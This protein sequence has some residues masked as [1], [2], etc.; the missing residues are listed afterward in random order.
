MS[1]STNCLLALAVAGLTA[2]ACS[3]VTNDSANSV[4]LSAAFQT[5]PAGFS[6]NSNSFDESGDDG[7]PFSPGT[8]D[9]ASGFHGQQGQNGERNDKDDHHDGFGKG[10]IRGLLM[11]G[12]LGS[13]FLGGVPFS[14]G[15]GF[16]PFGFFSLEDDCTFDATTGRV[17]CP[18]RIKRGLTISSSF[19]FKDAAGNAQPKFDRGVTNS[20]NAKIAVIGT[21]TRHGDDDGDDDND[22][23]TS[24]LDHR[25]DRTV[26]GLATGSTER[27]VNGTASAHEEITGERHDVKFTAVRDVSDVTTNVVIP[28]GE[29]RPTIPKSG[30]IVRE[31]K[32][33]ITPE[34]GETRTKTRKEEI[35]FDGTNVIKVVITQDDVT[36]NCTL[37]L[38]RKKLVCE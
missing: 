18:D 13:H 38:P 17:T 28:I 15:L 16:G 12:G 9:P 23:F 37:T 7:L 36:K 34:G 21:K 32:V 29:G 1:R 20:V 30:T 25:S 27:T 33:S 31:M 2:A 10:G 6:S 5:I 11:G 8:I 22:D 26:T 14:N 35:T 3:D 4:E 19:A 24:T